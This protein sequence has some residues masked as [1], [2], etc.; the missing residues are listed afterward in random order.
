[1]KFKE[2]KNLLQK[3]AQADTGRLHIK[4]SGYALRPRRSTRPKTK[5]HR[6]GFGNKGGT[7]RV[8]HRSTHKN[9]TKRTIKRLR[10]CKTKKRRKMKKRTL[11]NVHRIMKVSRSSSKTRKKN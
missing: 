4:D 2:F 5:P 9:K 10:T 7:R 3:E 1:M 11:R 6:F 8:C